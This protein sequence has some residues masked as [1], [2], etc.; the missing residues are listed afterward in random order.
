MIKLQKKLASV[1]TTDFIL[2]L[3]VIVDIFS[4]ASYEI[5]QFKMVNIHRRR[6]VHWLLRNPTFY[7]CCGSIRDWFDRSINRSGKF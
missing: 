1:V 6:G 7:H 5:R 3:L 4:G 2:K